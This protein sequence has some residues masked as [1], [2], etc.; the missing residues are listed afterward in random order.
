LTVA[1]TEDLTG[2]TH[3]FSAAST[4]KL[5]EMLR[6]VIN[7]VPVFRRVPSVAELY[8]LIIPELTEAPRVIVPASQREAGAV[9]VIDGVILTVAVT[10]VLDAEVHPFSVASA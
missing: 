1:V 3:P 8:Q 7:T 5:V 6:E 2:E 10:G 4:Q 9:A